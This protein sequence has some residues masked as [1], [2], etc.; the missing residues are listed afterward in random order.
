MVEYIYSG[1]RSVCASHFTSYLQWM[2]PGPH[3]F[4]P[5]SNM[6]TKENLNF[7]DAKRIIYNVSDVG[8]NQ[9]SNFKKKSVGKI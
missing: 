8:W 7:P 2:P 9:G 1:Q 5:W 4:L 6:P 3:Q